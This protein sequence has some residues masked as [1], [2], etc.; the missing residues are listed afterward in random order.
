MGW[1]SRSALRQWKLAGCGKTQKTDPTDASH[2][3][4]TCLAQSGRRLGPPKR[5]PNA[6]ASAAADGVAGMA[7]GAAVDR[8]A[9]VAGVLGDTRCD[10]ALAQ[11]CDKAGIVGLGARAAAPQ[12][13]TPWRTS[14]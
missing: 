10:V 3:A 7:C 14:P 2:P 8:R 5:S 4:M 12:L 13:S 1:D 6:F 11:Y 9:P